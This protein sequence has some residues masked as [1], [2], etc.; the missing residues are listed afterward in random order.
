MLIDTHASHHWCLIMKKHAWKIWLVSLVSV[1][2]WW[3]AAAAGH[4]N[5]RT[6]HGQ[7]FAWAAHWTHRVPGLE[8]TQVRHIYN[9]KPIKEDA[10]T[11]TTKAA[12][13]HFGKSWLVYVI[14]QMSLDLSEHRTRVTV[15]DEQKHLRLK[16]SSSAMHVRAL[17]LNCNF[18]HWFGFKFALNVLN[19]QAL[20]CKTIVFTWHRYWP[21]PHLQTN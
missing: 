12:G 19:V 2:S 20:Q 5:Y 10:C 1:L 9:L 4:C 13:G 11:C 14:K 8:A 15:L 17:P 21:I 6:G 16:Y 18:A 7:G 3:C